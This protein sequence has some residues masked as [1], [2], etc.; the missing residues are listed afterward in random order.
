MKMGVWSPS[1]TAHFN[2]EAD[3]SAM[4]VTGNVR[5]FPSSPFVITPTECAALLENT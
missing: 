5:H 3:E 2:G 1:P 4:L